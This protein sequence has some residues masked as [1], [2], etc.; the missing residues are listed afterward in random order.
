M[1]DLPETGVPGIQLCNL[2]IKHRRYRPKLPAY[3][4][5]VAYSIDYSWEDVLMSLE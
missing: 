1:H 2:R 5:V 4:T 3:L